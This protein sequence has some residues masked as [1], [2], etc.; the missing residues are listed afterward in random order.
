MAGKV[1]ETT[2]K[3]TIG[4]QYL[5]KTDKKWD[6]NEE[7]G[8]IVIGNTNRDLVYQKG[9]NFE[10]SE[11]IIFIKSELKNEKEKE[12]ETFMLFKLKNGNSILLRDYNKL[13]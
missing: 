2:V 5:D 10:Y 7:D 9:E 6:A 12:K 1:L 3:E 4:G 11:K 8:S 13:K